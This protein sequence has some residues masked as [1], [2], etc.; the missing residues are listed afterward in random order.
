MKER[1]TF[2]IPK[3]H[4]LCPFWATLFGVLSQFMW[5]R[6]EQKELAYQIEL[7]V[8]DR[9][10]CIVSATVWAIMLL[11]S[12][13]LLLIKRLLLHWGKATFWKGL[14]G[15]TIVTVWITGIRNTST[16]TSCRWDQ[17]GWWWIIEVVAHSLLVYSWLV[18]W[19]LQ[20][21]TIN[22]YRIRITLERHRYT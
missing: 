14:S 8:W 22:L 3:T 12:R 18:F 4:K 6:P 5:A 16:L 10:S 11:I 21:E 17:G 15:K 13:H 2:L 1:K 9:R 19:L 7:T 20:S